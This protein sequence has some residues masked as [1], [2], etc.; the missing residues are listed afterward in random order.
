MNRTRSLLLWIQGI[1]TLLTAL[2]GLLDIESFMDVSGP[3]T[4]VWLVKT[5]S[6]LLVPFSIFLLLCNF[7]KMPAVPVMV[8]AALTA[9]GL[10]S[11]DFYYT[12]NHTIRWVYA[13]DGVIESIFLL[14]WLI[15]FIKH[16][17]P[18]K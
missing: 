15:L 10:A 11:I 4:D 18:D 14:V 1:Y 12:A 9:A 6:V 3:K 7:Y 16:K 5:V 13:V 8:L 17:D 2:W